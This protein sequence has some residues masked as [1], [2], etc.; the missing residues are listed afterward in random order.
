[1]KILPDIPGCNTPI[2]SYFVL[3]SGDLITANVVSVN[4]YPCLIVGTFN[5]FATSF[6]RSADRCAAPLLIRKYE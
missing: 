3:S 1:M 4:P 6:V 5:R 2:L